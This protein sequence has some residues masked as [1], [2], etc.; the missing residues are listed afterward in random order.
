M[1]IEILLAF[2]LAST[3]IELTPGPNMAYLALI[4]LGEGRRAGFLTVTGIALGL[5][6]IGTIS[7]LGLAG[8]VSG[9]PLAYEILRWSGVAFLLYLAFDAWKSGET[10]AAEHTASSHFRRG[11]IT[12]LLNPKAAL[13]FITVIPAFLPQRADDVSANLVLV[14]IYVAVATVIHGAIVL[15]AGALTP[16]LTDPARA[17][18]MRRTMAVLLACVAIWFG[19]ST[20]NSA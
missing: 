20:A 12:N 18:R 9:S 17:T 13:F 6:V 14:A 5:A 19:L 8:I 10:E 1:S 2:V 7:A 11:L 16:Y 15:L 3:L 4:S